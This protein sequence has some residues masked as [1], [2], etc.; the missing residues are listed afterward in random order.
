MNVEEILSN[1]NLSK[2]RIPYSA[3]KSSV[4]LF[5]S[6]EESVRELLNKYID[7]QGE[8]IWLFNGTKRI[9][10]MDE[11]YISEQLTFLDKRN[12]SAPYDIAWRIIFIDLLNKKRCEKIKK[13]KDK[14]NE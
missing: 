1:L 9:K 5:K 11:D 12:H 3:K 8:L 10:Y 14:I 4:L 7:K 2:E 13:L 6:Q